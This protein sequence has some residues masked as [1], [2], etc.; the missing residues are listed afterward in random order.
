LKVQ[1]LEKKQV[2]TN[3]RYKTYTYDYWWNNTTN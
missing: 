1:R 2:Y 3:L